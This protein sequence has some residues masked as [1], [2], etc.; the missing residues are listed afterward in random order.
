M[1]NNDFIKRLIDRIEKL[2]QEVSRRSQNQIQIP[3]DEMS[4]NVLGQNM[5]ILS[6]GTGTFGTQSITVSSTPQTF[7][8]PAQPSGT[9]K[10]LINGVVVELLKK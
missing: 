8:V 7:T 5:V 6:T 9:V 10:V 4:K 1:E 3:L 2:E